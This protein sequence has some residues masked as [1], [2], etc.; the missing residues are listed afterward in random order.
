MSEFDNDE[1]LNKVLFYLGN[2]VMVLGFIWIFLLNAT[3]NFTSN[4]MVAA[5]FSI[6]VGTGLAF[7]S[8]RLRLVS[9]VVFVGSWALCYLFIEFV[10]HAAAT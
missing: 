3:G 1:H 6:F 4:W 7:G 2:I 10:K 8:G 5:V 9:A